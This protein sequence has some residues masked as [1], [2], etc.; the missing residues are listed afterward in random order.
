MLGLACGWPGGA[1]AQHWLRHKSAK[2]AF[3]WRFWC[4][5]A[6]NGGVFVYLSSGPF[7]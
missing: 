1:L 3:L 7:G 4:T 5:A 2:P 6:L